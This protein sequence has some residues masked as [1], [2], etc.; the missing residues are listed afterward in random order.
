M[1]TAAPSALKGVLAAARIAREGHRDMQ[2][3]LVFSGEGR[4]PMW[5]NVAA[6]AAS[7]QPSDLSRA[8][9]RE[10][11]QAMIGGRPAEKK[12]DFVY[13]L[14]RARIRSRS[15]AARSKSSAP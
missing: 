4:W 11:A 5:V 13:R 8:Y 9:E 6:K 14:A 1:E 3:G 2:G 15:L 7:F 10:R 12:K